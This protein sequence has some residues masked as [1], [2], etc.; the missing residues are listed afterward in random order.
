MDD[1]T[2]IYAPTASGVHALRGALTSLRLESQR[3]VCDA[4]PWSSAGPVALVGPAL[5]APAAVLAC[6][7]LLKTGPWRRLV[8]FGVC[9]GLSFAG[10]EIDIGDVI[11]PSEVI[12]EDGTSR[13]Y[14][15]PER[16][17]L[18]PFSLGGIATRHCPVWTTDAPL[19]EIDK[20]ADFFRRG[21]R[22]VDMELSALAWLAAQ[23]DLE[24]FACLVVSDLVGEVSRR[25]LKGARVQ[26]A[27]RTAARA[28]VETAIA[29]SFPAPSAQNP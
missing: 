3:P 7:S 11:L 18:R 12:C 24:F 20:A 13:S 27:L 6:E 26:D 29:E 1:R 23:H 22:A 17:P 8:L 5:G 16:F 19:K 10:S 14:G 15:A 9:G 4:V 2:L 25:E 28:L 21:A